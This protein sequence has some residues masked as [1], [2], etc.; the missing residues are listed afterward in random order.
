MKTILLLT[1]LTVLVNASYEK[2]Q[3]FYNAKNYKA[4]IKEVK[5]SPSEYSNPKLHLLWAKSAEALGKY[6]EAM[7]AYERVE[8]LDEENIEA[9]VALAKIYTKTKRDALAKAQ[10]VALENYQLSPQQRSSLDAIRETT[11]LHSFKAY[12]DLSFGYDS[13]IN[14]APSELDAGNS[15][16]EIA[17]GF[18]R[19]LGSLSYINEIESKGG[20]YARGDLQ[21]YNQSNIASEAQLYNL[22]LGS[23]SGGLGFN[24]GKFNYYLPVG[25][26]TVHYLDKNL[27][28]QVKVKPSL[29]YTISHDFIT[30][31]NL[32]YVQRS[33]KD[34]VDAPRD[35]TAF[36]LGVGGYYLFGKNFVYLNA[37]YEKFSQDDSSIAALFVDK[38]YF[39]TNMGVN[40]NLTP[41]IVT[42][43]DYR[44]R[45]ASFEDNISSGEKRSDI[46]NQLELKVSHYF[47]KN[48]ELFIKDRY[49]NNS[50]NEDA[51]TY[52][53]NIILL[54]VS[55][56]Y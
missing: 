38:T 13:N 42:R 12:A 47:M 15:S 49:I 22:F 9:R 6:E 25:Y 46:Y 19:F 3:D 21:V 7:S 17:S 31:F 20:W 34:P 40:Y 51:L 1:T 4:A 45:L 32:S 39:T 18:A 16:Q 53:K 35:D 2:A 33:Y 27:L 41:Y 11:D 37:K 28:S 30:N 24:D 55:A 56:N 10:A 36:G 43:F 44:V 14:I 26:D 29:N 5:A 54:G 50:S 48:Y 23:L 8:I 52:Q